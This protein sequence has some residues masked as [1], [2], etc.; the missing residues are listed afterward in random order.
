MAL[1][2]NYRRSATTPESWSSSTMLII[3]ALVAVALLALP[4]V[5]SEVT[6]RDPIVGIQRP[7]PG[8]VL[9]PTP[10]PAPGPVSAPSTGPVVVPAPTGEPTPSR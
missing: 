4:F 5:A 3:L 10:V 1:D 6:S 8:P 7:S 9:I 2:N